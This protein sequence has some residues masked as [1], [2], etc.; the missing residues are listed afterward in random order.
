MPNHATASNDV[1]TPQSER[2]PLFSR[3]GAFLL[4]VGMVI[5]F[6]AVNC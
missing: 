4:V 5:A 3:L 1:L 2:L 6:F